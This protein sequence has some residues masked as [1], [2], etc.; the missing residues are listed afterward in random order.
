VQPADP[1]FLLADLSNTWLIADIPEQNASSVS[2]G[3]E[4]HAEIPAYPEDK[5]EGKLSF[6]SATVNPETRTVG[7]RMNL[8]N[9]DGRYKPAM[10]ATMKLSDNP[11]K[12]LT[13][14]DTAI[15]R[16]ENQ[17]CLFVEK[18]SGVFTLRKVELGPEFNDYRV[19]LNGVGSGEKV[20]LDGAIHLNNQR[21]QNALQGGQ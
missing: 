19:L 8:P 2:L 6:V 5:I 15:V 9:P 14:P 16:E 12:K 3:K 21:K 10:L 20:V 18:A 11:Q 13:V 7:E 17:D 4:V 1:A